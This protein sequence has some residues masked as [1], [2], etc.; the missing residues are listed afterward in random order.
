MAHPVSHEQARR[1]RP[2]ASGRTRTPP[3][4]VHAKNSNGSELP[5]PADG[6]IDLTGGSGWDERKRV[7]QEV[8]IQVQS[9]AAAAAAPAARPKYTLDSSSDDGDG[10]L[11]SDDESL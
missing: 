11:T 3:Q 9:A 10:G 6:I 5:A 1:Q 2:D 8:D 7:G 4:T